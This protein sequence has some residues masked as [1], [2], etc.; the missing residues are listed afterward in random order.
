MK[1]ILKNIIKISA[2]AGAGYFVLGELLYQG[3]FNVRLTNNIVR[4]LKLED[5]EMMRIFYEEP[6]FVKSFQWFDALDLRDTVINEKGEEYH[7][8][9]LRQNEKS[10]NWL[11]CLHGYRGDRRAEAPFAKY[12]YE[13]GYNIAMPCM[14]GHEDDKNKY[15]TMGC[16][17]KDVLTGWINNIVREDPNSKIILH[18]VS[19]GASTVMLATG[20][21]L[22]DNVK[23]AVCD[24]GFDSSWDLIYTMLK[25]NYN[26][27][28]KFILNAVNG[29][30]IRRSGA[31]LRKSRPIDAL[32]RSK[33]PTLFVHGAKDNLVPLKVFYRVYEACGAYKDM[34][35]SE[36]AVHAVSVAFSYGE[37]IKKLESFENKFIK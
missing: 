13:K 31:D 4:A 18:G 37:Y 36:N 15:C 6:V 5:K 16:F 20:E 23:F 7:G 11:I 24:C 2:A 12:Y 3:I 10:H 34:L 25:E 9:V 22:P 17:D 26:L 30:S 32:R 27:P 28:A 8:Y 14:T 29:A 19:M 33:T 1:N 21:N 35:I